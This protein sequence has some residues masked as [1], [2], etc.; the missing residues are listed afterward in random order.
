MY[1]LSLREVVQTVLSILLFLFTVSGC[2]FVLLVCIFHLIP[3][4][5]LKIHTFGIYDFVIRYSVK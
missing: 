5:Q 1:I 4:L 3:F 2:S